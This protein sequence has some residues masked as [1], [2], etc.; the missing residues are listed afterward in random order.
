MRIRYCVFIFLC[1]CGGIGRRA[2]LR[3]ASCS[4]TSPNRDNSIFNDGIKT[5]VA[6]DFL[7]KKSSVKEFFLCQEEE[8]LQKELKLMNARL[9]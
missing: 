6:L 7:R 1:G 3:M 4:A 9:K 5:L 8:K 2:R